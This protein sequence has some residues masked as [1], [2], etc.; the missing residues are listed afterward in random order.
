MSHGLNKITVERNQRAVL[1]LASQPGNDVCADCKARN[2]RWASHNLGIF[3][4]MNCASV[5][6]KIGTHI[7]KVKSLTMDMWTKEQV[8]V[9]RST[10]NIKSNA[11]FNSDER[12]NPP[13]TNMVDAERDSEL[14][15][16]I[17]AKYEYKLFISRSVQAAALLGPSQSSTSRLAHVPPIRSQTVPALPISTSSPL[18]STPPPLPPK[19]TVAEQMPATNNFNFPSATMSPPQCR[20]VSQPVVNASSPFNLQ[21]QAP[22]TSTST[23]D[24]FKSLQTSTPTSS[25]PLQYT[26]SPTSLSTSTASRPFQATVTQ[27]AAATN[28]Y[29]SLSGASTTPFASSLSMNNLS[30]HTPSTIGRSMSLSTGLQ[31]NNT[32]GYQNVNPFQNAQTGAGFSA[33]VLTPGTAPRP[34]PFAQQAFTGSTSGMGGLAMQMQTQPSMPFTTSTYASQS[35]PF[36]Q[37]VSQQSQGQLQMQMPSTSSMFQPQSTSQMQMQMPMPAN[38]FVQLQQQQQQQ[39]HTPFATQPPFTMG[40]PSPFGQPQMQQQQTPGAFNPFA[41]GAGWQGGFAGQQRNGM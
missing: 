37:P 8:E 5:H 4:C 23:W 21:Q 41:A 40:T 11:Y 32:M 3:I 39:V 14:E 18:S 12:R 16:Y 24:P 10:G 29:S 7:S 33:P 2:P 17:R 1:E 31:V 35:S 30:G 22:S 38:P 34:N 25:L 15:K 26:P 27:G 28:P 6:R 19:T 20:P 13:P 36:G 9:M